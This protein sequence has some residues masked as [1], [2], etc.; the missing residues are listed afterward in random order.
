MRLIKVL[1]LHHY[2]GKF[3]I[4]TNV[5]R[6][7]CNEPKNKLRNILK[8]HERGMYQEL[9]PDSSA[10]IITKLM[11]K[12]PQCVYAGFDPTADS[13]HIG[14]LLILMN[15]LHW[16]RGGHSVIALVGGA[17]GLI[18][19][20]SHRT[21]E[22]L[23]ITKDIVKNN[24]NAIRVDIQT[25][26]ENHAKYFWR[27][28]PEKLT[29]VK[30]VDNFDWYQDFNVIDFVRNVGKHFRMG[31]MLNKSSVQT[32]LKSDTGM[33]FTEFTYQVF[34]A[35]DWLCLLNEYD[36]RFQIGGSDQLGNISAGHELISRVTKKDVFAF[37]LPLITAEGGKKFGKSLENAIW[38]SPRKSSSFQLYQFL[39]KTEDADVENYLKLFTFLSLK[40]I[41]SIMEEHRQKPELRRA[42]EMLADNVTL[43]VHG[44][45]G[46]QAAKTSSML[47][48]DK[49]IETLAAMSQEQ[50]A[51][52][53]EGASVVNI[54]PEKGIT[55]FEVAMKAKCFK[56]DREAARIIQAGGFYVNYERMTVPDQVVDFKKDM[57]P[58]NVTLL[59]TGKR[60]FHIVQWIELNEVKD[61]DKV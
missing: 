58:N 10:N 57:L 44:E 22:R 15:L 14:N 32:R 48:F 54:F 56:H 50:V 1:R 59:R 26:F 9:F 49:S 34:Q 19:D 46:L 40:Q 29:P 35:Y 47:L 6:F 11:D 3:R 2:P 33:S 51:L 12:S 21:K 23:P 61:A 37:T 36:C 27:D 30:I 45:E 17:T 7:Y 60:T 16:Q 20:P 5:I 28:S 8:L 39:I 41:N 53:F 38:L 13:L 52:A 18:G 43:L 24:L 25:I 42:Q 31:T 4:G 55:F